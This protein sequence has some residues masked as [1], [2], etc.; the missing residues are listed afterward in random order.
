MAHEKVDVEKMISMTERIIEF[1]KD[2][3][4]KLDLG[5]PECIMTLMTAAWTISLQQQ[6]K[7]GHDPDGFRE[8]MAKTFRNA[9]DA[10]N[11]I[12]MDGHEGKSAVRH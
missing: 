2:E 5:P 1:A 9:E 4:I 12:H 6:K 11:L 3:C 7:P 8:A 10:A